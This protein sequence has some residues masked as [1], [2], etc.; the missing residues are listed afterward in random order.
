MREATGTFLNGGEKKG[1]V[2]SFGIVLVASGRWD[3]AERRNLCHLQ[4]FSF[5]VAAGEMSSKLS[6]NSF[7]QQL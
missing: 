3:T 1:V 5:R 2:S 7:V 6:A 4:H